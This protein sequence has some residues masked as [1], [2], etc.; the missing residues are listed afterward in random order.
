MIPAL[1][2]T[3][4]AVQAPAQ[5]PAFTDVVARLKSPD[6]AA[7]VE[8]IE[9][10]RQTNFPQAIPVLAPLVVDVDDRV[11]LAAIDAELAL[12]LAEDIA[13]DRRASRA[14]RAF[15][16]A[17][18]T[19]LPRPVPRELVLSLLRAVADDNPQVRVDAAYLLGTIAR[20]PLAA[21]D[22]QTVITALQAPDP[23]TRQ[24]MA[25]VAGRLQLTRAGDALVNAMNDEDA[26]VR[27]AAIRAVGELRFERG[28]QSLVDFVK[29]YGNSEIGFAAYAALARIGHAS[30]V[31]AFRAGLTDGN[32]AIRRLSAE[33]AG[34]AHD[35]IVVDQLALLSTDKDSSVRAAADFALQL[36][37]RAALDRL[38]PLLA[39]ARAHVQTRDYLLELGPSIAPGLVGYLQSPDAPVR[40]GVIE[41][42]GVIGGADAAR[43]VGA[44][45]QD[46]DAQVR[47][48]VT[49]A[50]ERLRLRQ[51][52]TS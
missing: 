16:G 10:L 51:A 46:P 21:G 6:A 30:S 47:A 44:L 18:F 39:D 5:Q 19:V 27:L 37:G 29:Y 48:A 52:S 12:F 40:H 34:R 13:P 17:P 38:V 1:I 33:G 32:A 42:L 25:R 4:L 43:A 28:V 45:Q 9:T 26:S 24:A 49:R 23:E 36:I 11:Q 22:A 2:L 3:L 15:E 50:L 14:A 35:S 31:A 8:A 20:P 7:R 41:V